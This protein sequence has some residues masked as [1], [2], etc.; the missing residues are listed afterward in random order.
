MLVEQKACWQFG[1]K[2]QRHFQRQAAD[3]LDVDNAD[4]ENRE[5]SNAKL[6]NSDTF[7]KSYTFVNTLFEVFNIKTL[8][9][10]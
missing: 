6:Q 9:S 5:F 7:L 4:N 2:T 8:L 3:C 10:S 1:V